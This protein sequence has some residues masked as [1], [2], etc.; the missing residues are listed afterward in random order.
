[1]SNALYRVSAA[2]RVSEGRKKKGERK[3]IALLAV[4]RSLAG[5]F[6]LLE[7]YRRAILN[8]CYSA[9]IIIDERADKDM[10]EK[11]ER[12]TSPVVPFLPLSLLEEEEIA[13]E[14]T[15]LSRCAQPCLV[16]RVN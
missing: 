4:A 5:S 9:R 2:R 7:R 3:R 1:V 10:D 12:Q 14:A 6:A 15:S 13:Y 16:D 8:S 11:L